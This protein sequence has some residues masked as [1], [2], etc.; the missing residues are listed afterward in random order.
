MATDANAEASEGSRSTEESRRPR[1]TP[2]RAQRTEEWWRSL[3]EC[4][5]ISLEPLADLDYPPFVLWGSTPSAAQN[6][7]PVAQAAPAPEG[8]ARGQYYD[9]RLLAAYVVSCGRFE[10]LTTRRCADRD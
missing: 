10:C 9:G 5:P 8:A 3:K 2:P 4:D 6:P 1:Q 7:P